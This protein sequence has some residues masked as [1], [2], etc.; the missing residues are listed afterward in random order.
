MSTTALPRLDPATLGGARAP[1]E[2]LVALEA[3]VARVLRGKPGVIR[4]AV[5]AL[6]ARGHLLIEDVPGVGKTTLA[7]ALARS[8]GGSFHRIQFTSD[9]LPSD[10]LGVSMLDPKIGRVRV[11]AR[12][13]VR[14]PGAGRRDQPDAAAHAERAARGD[15]RRTGV[16][17]RAALPARDPVPGDGDAELRGALRDLPAPRVADGPLP[18]ERCGSTTRR[19]RTSGGSCSSRPGAPRRICCASRRC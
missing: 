1:A 17:G 18:A 6:C 8:I 12:A 11:Q 9:L 10:V 4:H 14:Q 2:L 13:G 19:P 7:R 5:I 15:E 3:N 16:G